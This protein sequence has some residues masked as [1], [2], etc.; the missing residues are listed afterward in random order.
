MNDVAILFIAPFSGLKIGGEGREWT[1][2][3]LMRVTYWHIGSPPGNCRSHA[4]LGQQLRFEGL[5]R[6]GEREGDFEKKAAA[7]RYVRYG[8]PRKLV[9]LS[10]EADATHACITL[11]VWEGRKGNSYLQH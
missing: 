5:R 4:I 3:K 10:S 1:M 9:G 8:Q 2:G 7:A 6:R 11:T